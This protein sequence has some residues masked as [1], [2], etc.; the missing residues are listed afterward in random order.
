MQS[1]RPALWPGAARTSANI[2]SFGHTQAVDA[3]IMHRCQGAGG[4]H[5]SLNWHSQQLNYFKPR[6]CRMW[7]AHSLEV[8]RWINLVCLCLLFFF[9]SNFFFFLF[10]FGIC[11]W[12]NESILFLSWYAIWAVSEGMAESKHLSHP[13]VLELF[14]FTH[15]ALMMSSCLF[16]VRFQIW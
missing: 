11:I 4:N 9:P 1:P 10:S 2:P 14:C 13:A 5:W 7:L 6:A 16:M 8:K 15:A 12:L 3:P